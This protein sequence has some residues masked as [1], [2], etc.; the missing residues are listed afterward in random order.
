MVSVER[1]VFGDGAVDVPGGV[2]IAEHPIA[3]RIVGQV[4]LG[5]AQEGFGLVPL[6]LL[7]QQT[8]QRSAR[9]WILGID[10]NGMS[11]LRLGFGK[12]VAR[13]IESAQRELRVSGFRIDF[14]CLFEIIFGLVWEVGAELKQRELQ[15][16]LGAVGIECDRLF[17]FL[18]S[19]AKILLAGVVAGPGLMRLRAVG[20]LALPNVALSLCLLSTVLH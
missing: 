13:L 7:H 12:T 11:E 2:K 5:L 18:H 20:L 6:A 10:R 17:H 14:G 9:S 8:N 3:F 1:T 4:F 19:G 16:G 15:V